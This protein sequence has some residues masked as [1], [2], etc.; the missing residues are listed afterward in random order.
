MDS[1]FAVCDSARQSVEQLTPAPDK[2]ILGAFEQAQ[3][4]A[5][6]TQQMPPKVRAFFER[7]DPV[8]A[9]DWESEAE[10]AQRER[11]TELGCWVG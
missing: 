8:P 6:A 10:R 9:R 1:G 4:F 2:V 7:E 3:R 11:L 5:A